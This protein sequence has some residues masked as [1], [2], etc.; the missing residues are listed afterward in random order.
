[1]QNPSVKEVADL[2]KKVQKEQQDV[3]PADR[4]YD[5][6]QYRLQVMRKESDNLIREIVTQLRFALRHNTPSN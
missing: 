4:E 6:F 1:M 5:K 2:L 3:L